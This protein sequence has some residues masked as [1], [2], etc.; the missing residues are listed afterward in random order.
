MLYLQDGDI[1]R[2]EPL[3]QRAYDLGLA[4]TANALSEIAMQHGDAAASES[5]WLTGSMGVDFN[6]TRDELV[7]VHR[8]IFGDAAA[9][10]AAVQAL[11]GVLARMGSK[12]AMP[13]LPLYLFRVPAHGFSRSLERLRAN[14]I[15]VGWV[16]R[17]FLAARRLPESQK[18]AF[19]CKT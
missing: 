19:M 6:M 4:N 5:L 8:G 3:L 18:R 11:Q 17:A 7:V 10:Q 14:R 1:A 13:A 16:E 12:R 15:F 2:A 9:K